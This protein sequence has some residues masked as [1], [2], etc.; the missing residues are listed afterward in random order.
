MA[1]SSR[2]KGLSS[3][4]APESTGIQELLA[5][6][7]HQSKDIFVGINR[8]NYYRPLYLTSSFLFAVLAISRLLQSTEGLDV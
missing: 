8:M 6:G 7:G 3:T 4:G 1:G 5:L 2:R